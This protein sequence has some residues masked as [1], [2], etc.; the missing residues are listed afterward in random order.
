MDA[1]VRRKFGVKSGGH[2]SSL[3]DSDG[4]GAFRGEDFDAFANALDLGGADEDHFERRSGRIAGEVS[5]EFT[6]A[7]G[8]VDLASVGIA[9]DANVEG[10]ESGLRGIFD[11]GGEQD[12]ASAGAEGGLEADELFEL[13]E[14][15]FAKKFEKRTGFAAGNDEAIDVVE[16]LGLFDEHDVSAQLFEPAAV[17]IEITLQGQDT[18]DHGGRLH[19]R[20]T[21]TRRTQEGTR[22]SP[23]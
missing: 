1:G 3:P 21:E 10:A 5:E 8:A 2:G 17:G 4:I 16:L 23:S 15:G 7:N 9:A 19:H 22:A 6:F 18:D 12:G 13:F 20:S 14:S 11:F